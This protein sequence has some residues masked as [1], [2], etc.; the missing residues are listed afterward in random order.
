[1]PSYY[2]VPLIGL[3]S[4]P[5][6]QVE[7]VNKYQKLPF[8]LVKNE[9][10]RFPLYKTWDLLFGSQKWTPNMGSI[11]RGVR[12]EYSPIANSFVYP[13]NITG[14]P[15]KNV[16]ETSES[17]EEA[18]IKIHRFESKQFHF[19]P[20][21]Q[22][23]RE[24]QLKWNHDDIIRQIAFYNEQFIRGMVFYRSP[25]IYICNNNGNSTQLGA[26]NLVVGCPT[27]DPASTVPND[28]KTAAFLQDVAGAVGGNF[29]LRS[30]YNACQVLDEDLSAPTFEGVNN[31]PKEN[32]L[33]QGRYVLVCGTEVWRNFLVDPMVNQLK[34]IQS[35]P[36]VSM[37]SKV[38]CLDK[39]LVSLRS[40]RFV[41][42]MMGL[43]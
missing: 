22:D 17:T 5:N 15:N 21:F 14:L 39:L 37:V 10:K 32:A 42:L 11:M 23:F 6:L 24:N 36:V 29:S 26:S 12:P 7:D 35:G 40:S 2:D 31:S 33:V 1:M 8:Y 38:L 18:R 43:S 4:I 25:N 16:F 13:Q 27:N 9:V 34:A 41:W 20:S 28:G 30:L 3:D 19:L